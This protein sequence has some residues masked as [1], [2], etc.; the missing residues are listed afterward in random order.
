MFQKWIMKKMIKS[1]LKGVPEEQQDMLI[2]TIIKNPDFFK[3]IE[4]EIKEKKKAGMNEQ[5][6]MMQVMR[7][8]QAQMQ[9]LFMNNQQGN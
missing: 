4:K 6:A 3:Q 1:K 2:D 5:A 7:S 9:K 8:H